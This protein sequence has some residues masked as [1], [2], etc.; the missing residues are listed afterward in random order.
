MLEDGGRVLEGQGGGMLLADEESGHLHLRALSLCRPT[1]R[2]KG[3]HSQTLVERCFDHNES[4]LCADVKMELDVRNVGSVAHGAMTSIIRALLR[5]PRQRIGVLHLDL[6]PLQQPFSR[7]EFHL[8]DALAATVSVGIETA[9]LLE[10]QR[11]QFIQT[12][13]ALGRA[14]EI[15]DQYTANHTNRVTA[16]ALL[17]A[18]EM[19]IAD[20]EMKLLQ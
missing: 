5:T 6:G 13:T 7:E 12:V 9:Y 17:L 19:S 11:Q 2:N 18:E 14:V 8:A 20:P 10:K 4:M 3:T 1:L 16:Y 15:R